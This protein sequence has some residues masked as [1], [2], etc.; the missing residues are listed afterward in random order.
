MPPHPTSSNGQPMQ[1]TVALSNSM[2][3]KYKP[4]KIFKNIVDPPA[5]G[6]PAQ[7]TNNGPRHITGITFDDRGDTLVT[8]AEDETFR[9]WSCKTGKQVLCCGF[10]G[11][12]SWQ[13]QGY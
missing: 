1:T 13:F 3:S 6:T 4:A 11:L 8:S 7:R 9:L 2:M 10:E 12:H 5:A